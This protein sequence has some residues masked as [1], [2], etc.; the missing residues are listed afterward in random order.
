MLGILFRY[1]FY[2][3]F[4]RRR[5]RVEFS[6]GSDISWLSCESCWIL[7]DPLK[8]HRIRR[9]SRNSVDLQQFHGFPAIPRDSLDLS[10]FLLSL[11]A[12]PDSPSSSD[13]S[14]FCG[15]SMDL[16]RFLLELEHFGS[17][18]DTR[19]RARNLKANNYYNSPRLLLT[20]R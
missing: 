19:Q 15:D 7:R 6:V 1:F 3:E 16:S 8:F 17:L 10:R 9:I 12:S 4:P 2:L 18:C 5:T 20:S 14:G 13:P 11:R